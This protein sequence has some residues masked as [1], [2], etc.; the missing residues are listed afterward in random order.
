[1]SNLAGI[2]LR[3]QLYQNCFHLKLNNE[4]LVPYIHFIF[5]YFFNSIFINLA[6]IAIMEEHHLTF[7][8]VK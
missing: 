4:E 1:L 7:E 5:I 6:I 8:T 2:T 3:S